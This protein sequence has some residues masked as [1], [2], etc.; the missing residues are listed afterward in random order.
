MASPLVVH[1][2][3]AGADRLALVALGA[4]R[5]GPHHAVGAPDRDADVVVLHGRRAAWRARGLRHGRC[6]VVHRPAVGA[7]PRRDDHRFLPWCDLVV[8]RDESSATELRRLLGRPDASVVV[9]G[10]DHDR[11][12]WNAVVASVLDPAP[13]TARTAPARPI[14]PDDELVVAPVARRRFGAELLVAAI[15]PERGIDRFTGS[16]P[17]LWD[18]LAAGGS[19]AEVAERVRPPFADHETEAA[20]DADVLAFARHLVRLGLAVPA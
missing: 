9:L 7:R 17:R 1:V 16:A 19:I 12:G 15:G 8:A 20:V 6:V 10:D 2:V 3:S 13:A 14:G 18:E 4:E 5:D 11:E